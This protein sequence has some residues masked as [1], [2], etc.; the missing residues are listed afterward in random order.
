MK[1]ENGF[2]G[3]ADDNDDDNDDN[4]NDDKRRWRWWRKKLRA[5]NLFLVID[6]I[7][8]ADH[9]IWKNCQ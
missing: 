8:K 5:A 3:G 6:G 7:F 9:R 2:G 4:D 1:E